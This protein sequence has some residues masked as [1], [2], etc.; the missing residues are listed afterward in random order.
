MTITS[1]DKEEKQCCHRILSQTPSSIRQLAAVSALS[2]GCLLDGVVLAYSS[3]ALPS[4][5]KDT[6]IQLDEHHNSWIGSAHSLGAILGCILSIPALDKLGRR[7]ASLYVMSVAYIIGFI[8]I[9]LATDPWLIIVG[10]FFGGIGLGLTLSV[11]PVY[12]VEVTNLDLRGMLGVVPPLFTQAGILYTYV[13]GSFIDWRMLSLSGVSL[14]LI[15]IIAVWFIPES[16]LYLASKAKF[17]SAER[18]LA[19]LGREDDS[20]KF[21]KEVQT[22]M[23]VFDTTMAQ[24]WRQYI[25]PRV[26]K[27]F[28]ACLSLMFFFQATGYNTILAYSLTIFHETGEGLD[29]NVLMGIKGSIILLS[30]VIALG[31]ARVC[32]RKR[33]LVS[34]CLGVSSSLLLLGVYYFIKENQLLDLGDWHFVP[35]LFLICLIIFFMI[36]Y[37]GLT[38]TVM[39]EIM[40]AKVRSKLYPFTVAFTWFCSFGFNKTFP[41]L[42]TS[43]GLSGTFWGYAVISLIG[44]IFVIFAIPETKN[45]SSEEVAAFFNKS[46]ISQSS[47]TQSLGI[48]IVIPKDL[49]VV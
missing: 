8:L 9:G 7:G 37:G 36:G 15:F 14:G 49:N 40:P 2:L 25:D 32:P 5:H 11:T 18:S 44:S 27:P 16:P 28:L 12:L 20:V 26:Y 3:P 19:W 33:L 46:P 21:F 4:L 38:W 24:S 1:E 13:L 48:E 30:A 47:S 35:L 23:N 29:D 39:A 31:M 22:D 34:S 43:I 17:E 6:S 42:K 10:R 41:Y 45:K